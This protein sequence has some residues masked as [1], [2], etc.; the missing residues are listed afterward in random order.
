MRITLQSCISRDTPFVSF[1]FL[2]SLN[3]NRMQRMPERLS[4]SNSKDARAVVRTA[5]A[6]ASRSRISRVMVEK[7][8]VVCIKS[9]LLCPTSVCISNKDPSHHDTG[10]I[11]SLMT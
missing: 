3:R 2:V 6:T 7:S 10:Y 4:P 5:T 8:D 1:F 9:T 11:V